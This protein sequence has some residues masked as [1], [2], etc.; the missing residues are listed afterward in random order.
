MERQESIVV[1]YAE[2]W[3]VSQQDGEERKV[4]AEQGQ[5][6]GRV[7]VPVLRVRGGGVGQQGAEA[8]GG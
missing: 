5:V 1:V 6:D 7:P 8:D 2:V 3:F 4:G